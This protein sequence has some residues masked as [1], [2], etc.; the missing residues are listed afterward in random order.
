[1]EEMQVKL[2]EEKE[3]MMAKLSQK[4]EEIR[5]T[6]DK[7]RRQSEGLRRKLDQLQLTND[8]LLTERSVLTDQVLLTAFVL[9]LDAHKSVCFVSDLYRV[10][11]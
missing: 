1:M 10:G 3:E 11:Q 7:L 9:F 2:S 6:S 8:R 5:L 4:D